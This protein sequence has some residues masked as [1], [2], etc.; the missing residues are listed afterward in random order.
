[1]SLLPAGPFSRRVATGKPRPLRAVNYHKKQ[2]LRLTK[3][4]KVWVAGEARVGITATY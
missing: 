1:V 2:V 3:A 4:L